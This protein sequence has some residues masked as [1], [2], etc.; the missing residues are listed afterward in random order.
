VIFRGDSEVAHG[1]LQKFRLARHCRTSNGLGVK[2]LAD[3]FQ[4]QRSVVG[5]DCGCF[6]ANSHGN[7]HLVRVRLALLSRLL[8]A[9]VAQH[10]ECT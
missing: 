5:N 10:D 3:A 2:V 6:V 1:T 8:C 9:C 7:C 4:T